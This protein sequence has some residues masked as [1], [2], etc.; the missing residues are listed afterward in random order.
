MAAILNGRSIDTS[1]G[2]TP[3]A[4][5][6]M[7]TRS[8]D[9]DPSIVFDLVEKEELSL[10]EV[11][12]LLNRHSGLLGLSGYASDMRDV[13]TEAVTGDARCREAIDVYCYRAKAYLGQY[14]AVLNGCDAIV[15]TAGIGEHSPEIRAQICSDLENL[16]IRLDEAANREAIGKEMRI[17][18]QGSTVQV[19]TIPTD[20]ELVIAI[21]AMKIASTVRRA[22]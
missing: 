13:L 16:G 20:E 8:G 6:V 18:T 10:S 5:L 14:I 1:M 4:G 21:D 2:L 7:G 19:W 15:F 12:A 11:H 17:S 22:S 3:L 9:I